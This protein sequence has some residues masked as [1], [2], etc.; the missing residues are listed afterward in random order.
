MSNRNPKKI[1]VSNISRDVRERDLGRLFEEVG[2]IDRLQFK[3]RFAF[4]E[5]ERSRECEDAVHKF[6]GMFFMGRRLRVEPYCY[7]GGDRK[8]RSDHYSNDYRVFITNLDSMTSWQDLKDFGRT[9][10]KSVTF[11]DVRVLRDSDDHSRKNQLE[12]IIEYSDINDFENALKE[13]DGARLNG[14]E[15][16]STVNQVMIEAN[17][18]KTTAMTLVVVDAPDRVQESA[19]RAE[20][21]LALHRQKQTVT[22]AAIMAEIEMRAVSAENDRDHDPEI[23]ED[24]Q[25]AP[26]LLH[27]H[28][29]DPCPDIQLTILRK[30][31][32]RKAMMSTTAT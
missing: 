32:L 8:Y 20:N 26:R 1:Y 6:D 23:T 14:G 29:Q 7:R 18:A 28:D 22:A 25:D 27:T 17:S 30:S 12:G 3:N 21:I 15:S 5:F 9:A 10:G 19:L 4:V 31:P 24:G 11:A 13:L 16:K 2:R